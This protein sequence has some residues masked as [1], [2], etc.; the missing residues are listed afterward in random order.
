VTF[1]P[2]GVV[3][4]AVIDTFLPSML[5][6]LALWLDASNTASLPATTPVPTWSDVS[7]KGFHYTAAGALQP[8]REATGLNGKPCVRFDGTQMMTRNAFVAH[9]DSFLMC[10]VVRTDAGQP[11]TIRPWGALGDNSHVAAAQQTEGGPYYGWVFGGI[12]WIYADNAKVDVWDVMTVHRD[13]TNTTCRSLGV[14]LGGPDGTTPN[15][16]TNPS[17][18]GGDAYGPKPKCRIAEYVVVD[19]AW[20][21]TNRDRLESY[22]KT[23][24]G[25]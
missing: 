8:T 13:G 14:Q 3:A 12:A 24:W 20:T 10:A 6:N 25:L 7:G 19:G 16:A 1:A 21:A 4:S 9:V 23:K 17:T 5:P 11:T 15:P 22:L 2:A 18:I